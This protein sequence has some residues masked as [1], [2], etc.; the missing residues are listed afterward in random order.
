MKNALF[1][2]IFILLFIGNFYSYSI[3]TWSTDSFGNIALVPG[4]N[5]LTLALKYSAWLIGLS[6]SLSSR[7][8]KILFTKNIYSLFFIIYSL[9]IW[10]I[11]TVF[12]DGLTSIFWVN[13]SPLAYSTLLLIPLGC[14][15]NCWK[16]LKAISIPFA[17]LN[18][19]LAIFWNYSSNSVIRLDQSLGGNNPILTYLVTGFWWLAVAIIDL[20][21][22]GVLP[23]MIVFILIVCCGVLAFQLTTRSW[24]IQSILLLL[25]WLSQIDERKIIRL[26]VVS[27]V[28]ILIVLLM[29]SIFESLY[30]Q[31]AIDKLVIK[32]QS[33]TRTF[34]YVEMFTQVPLWKWIIGGGMSAT[35]ISE[36]TGGEYAFIDNQILLALFH[37]GVLLTIPWFYLWFK[38][39]FQA[40]IQKSRKISEKSYMFVLI[41]WMFALG[42]LSVYNVVIINQ[43]TVLMCI[44]LGYCM[45]RNLKLN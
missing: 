32:N 15:S 7:Y 1:N 8:F 11:I 26:I 22:R 2:L 30:W 45:S 23:K 6:L 18:I 41:L 10:T 33:D 42:G 40:F 34:Q 4:E 16:N 31:D 38:A 9:L 36:I 12:T 21:Q 13:I 24:M 25:M 29:N 35:Y 3:A 44:V 27:I 28:A 5:Y 39:I 37:Y 14:D 43:N 20:K 19:G 17:I